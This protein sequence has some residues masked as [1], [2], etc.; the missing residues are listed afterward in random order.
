MLRTNH[1]SVRLSGPVF[2]EIL[3]MYCTFRQYW[4]LKFPQIWLYQAKWDACMRSSEDTW[5]E[6]QF[7][8]ISFFSLFT[9]F[10]AVTTLSQS[11]PQKFAWQG[12]SHEQLI[13]E[14][15]QSIMQQTSVIK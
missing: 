10:Y 3:C 11:C 5:F 9:P 15:Q 7:Y 6:S 14:P 4:G 13:H 1:F 12:L 2:Q 8:Q